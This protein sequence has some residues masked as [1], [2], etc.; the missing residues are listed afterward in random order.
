MVALSQNIEACQLRAIFPSTIPLLTNELRIAMLRIPRVGAPILL[1]VFFLISSCVAQSAEKSDFF[2]TSDN[3]RLHYIEAGTGPAI[4]F[5]PGWTMPAEIWRS[6]I[7][8]FAHHYHVVAIDP[9]SQGE[10]DKPAD[11]NYPERRAQDIHELMD[12]L[13]LTQAVLVGWS[14][15]VPELL[16]YV[17]QFGT[18][19]V[20]ALVL[21]DSAPIPDKPNPELVAGMLG[22]FINVETDRRKFTDTFVRSMYKKAQSEAYLQSVIKASLQTPSNTAFALIPGMLARSD[23]TPAINKIDK[24]VLSTVTAQNHS[25]ADEIK[26]HIPTAQTEIFED[27]GHALFVDDAS[28]FNTTLEKFIAALP[29]Q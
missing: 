10:S 25:V 13:R 4:V 1:I 14:L 23:W 21:V 24:P 20:R 2:T 7:D 27:A 18:K 8:Y 5:Q 12:H 6:Q 11:G 28:R 22:W 19:A 16:S 26:K 9:R 15:G 17:D 3:V 29:A